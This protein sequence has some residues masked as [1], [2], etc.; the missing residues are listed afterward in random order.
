MA[1]L[2][3]LA[4]LILTL[5]V[6][7]GCGD[8]RTPLAAVDLALD[9]TPNAVHAPIYAA[10][11]RDFDRANGIDLRI[12]QP[13]EGPDSL[14]LVA[15]GRVALGVLDIGDLAIARRRGIDVV[16]VGALIDRP[17]AALIAQPQ[18]TRPR[19]LE[20]TTIG[21]SGLPSDPAFVRAIMAHDGGDA[22]RV[23][24]LT[25]GFAAVS[26]L[27][28]RRVAA[29]PAFWN[30]E[31]IALRRRGRKVREFR[32]DDY[33]APPYPEVVLMTARATLR[34]HRDRVLA[35]L[36]AIAAGADEVRAHPAAAVR[37]IAAAAQTSDL[38]LIRAQLDAV[39]PLFAPGLRLNRRIIERWADFELRIGLV[40][41]RPQVDRGFD[42]SLAR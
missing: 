16:V 2:V 18:I 5:V 37:Q 12:R 32:V 42:F 29:V 4:A 17:L 35:A 24:E 27:L 40:D 13:G 7:A 25:I 23:R 9:F 15:S 22:R 14:K 28:T 39:T 8:G 41:R 33:G 10:V 31:G 20:G 21:V 26:A 6:V 30:A 11:R 3:A 19:D 36:R 34:G 1:R 38:G